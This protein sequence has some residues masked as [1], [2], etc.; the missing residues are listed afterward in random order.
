MNIMIALIPALFWGILPLVVSSI[1]GSPNNQIIG[2][3]LGAFVVALIVAIFV[4]ANLVWP[5]IIGGAGSGMCWAFGQYLQY[6]SFT[7]IDVSKAMPVSTGLQ[8]IGTSLF[9]VC[10]FGEWKSTKML[11]FFAILLVIAGVYLTTYTS[12]KNTSKEQHLLTGVGILIVSMFGYIGYSALPRMF[13]LSG[14][15][16]FLPQ[17]AGMVVMSLLLSIKQLGST[18]KE[19][20]TYWSMLPGLIF[21]VAALGYL[22]SAQRNGVATGFTLSQMSVIISTLGGIF[23]LKEHKTRKELILTLIGLVLVLSGGIIISQI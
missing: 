21:A 6:V 5:V 17:T 10:F 8:L 9:S 14:W 18:L 12:K 20:Q 19:K 15:D 1:G 13:N 7:K 16:A 2:T 3:T 4:P 23:I 22:I 11:G